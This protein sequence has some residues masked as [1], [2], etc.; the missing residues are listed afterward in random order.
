M[1]RQHTSNFSAVR[2]QIV[3]LQQ[4]PY[5]GLLPDPVVKNCRGSHGYYCRK[6]GNRGDASVVTS[7]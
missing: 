4:A 6:Q 3:E 5:Q 7:C 2:R 1:W